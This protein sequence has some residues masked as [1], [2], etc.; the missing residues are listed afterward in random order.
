MTTKCPKSFDEALIS[1]FLDGE[2]TQADDQRVRVHLEACAH[3][4]SL[5]DELRNMREV[6]MTTRFETP[7]DDQWNEAPTGGVSSAA[8]GFGWIMGVVWIVALTGFGL[9]HAATGP[10]SLPEKLFVFGGISAVALLFLSVLIDR[11]RKA[12]TDRYREVQK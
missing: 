2:L 10:E 1:G 5:L 6:A 11:V 4:S 3:C 9:W 7:T 8:R 12:Q